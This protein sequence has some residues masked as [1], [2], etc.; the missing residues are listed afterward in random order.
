M[1]LVKGP[2]RPRGHPEPSGKQTT[3]RRPSIVPVEGA[4]GSEDLVAKLRS[5]DGS[6]V[7]WKVA[8]LL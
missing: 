1:S 5:L 3:E 7:K 6:L 2:E 4:G 8:G